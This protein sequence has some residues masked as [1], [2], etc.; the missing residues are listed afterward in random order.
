MICS[1]LLSD[2]VAQNLIYYTQDFSAQY[3]DDF[4]ELPFNVDSLR[5]YSERVVMASAPWQ[6]WLM[7][8]RSVSRWEDPKT[9]GKWLA[10]YV[11]LWYTEHVMGFLVSPRVIVSYPVLMLRSVVLYNLH[12]VEGTVPTDIRRVYTRFPTE[13]TG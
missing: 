3:I 4:D 13:G 5:H 11:F 1:L 10:L 8:V 9:T 12:S 6:A 7:N 2:T